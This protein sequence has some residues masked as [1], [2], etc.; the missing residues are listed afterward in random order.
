LRLRSNGRPAPAAE[1][2]ILTVGDSFTFGDEVD[3]INTWPSQ[4]EGLLQQR[5][6]NAGVFAYGIDQAYLRAEKLADVYN[7]R[8]IVLAFIDSDIRRTQLSYYQR[9]W[10]PYF[11]YETNGIQLRNVPIP[12]RRPASHPF[13]I[14]NRALGY[15]YLAN[16]V[17]MRTPV[18]AWYAGP[19][20]LAVHSDGER[21]TVELLIRLDRIARRRNMMFVAVPLATDGRIGGNGRLPSVVTRLRANDVRVV[22]LASEMLQ[23]QRERFVRM[24]EGRGHYSAEMNNWVAGRLAMLLRADMAAERRN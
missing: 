16:A 9:R 5:V 23:M 12:E 15:S 7:P 20:E 18:R 17:L 13:P 4:L 6:L 1:G 8:V 19:G 21:I 3:D 2:G 24:F 14:L 22:D 10:K 11:E